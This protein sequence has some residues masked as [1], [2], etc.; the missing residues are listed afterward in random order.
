MREVDKK[1]R[2]RRRR[3]RVGEE[4]MEDGVRRGGVEGRRGEGGER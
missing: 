1:M 3:M 4:G 2:R